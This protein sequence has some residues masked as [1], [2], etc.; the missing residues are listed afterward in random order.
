MNYETYKSRYEAAYAKNARRFNLMDGGYSDEELRSAHANYSAPG[1]WYWR[2]FKPSLLA[3]T[4]IEFYEYQIRQALE[5]AGYEPSDEELR[6]W[7]DNYHD[8]LAEVVKKWSR[9]TGMK[10]KD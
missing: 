8:A 9:E 1:I 4:N 3:S 2:A 6:D 5:W 10:K 7:I